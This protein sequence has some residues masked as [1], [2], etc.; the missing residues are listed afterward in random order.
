M[1]TPTKSMLRL[2]AASAA[3]IACAATAMNDKTCK[4]ESVGGKAHISPS[5]NFGTG[6]P[7]PS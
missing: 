6:I 7:V 4:T 1:H 3:V 2:P 5:W